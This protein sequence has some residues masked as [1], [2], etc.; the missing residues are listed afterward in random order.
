MFNL[1]LVTLVLCV[2]LGMKQADCVVYYV[3]SLRLNIK[4]GK[5]MS[6][7]DSPFSSSSVL[8]SLYI[9][10]I[11]VDMGAYACVT[12]TSYGPPPDYTSPPDYTCNRLIGGGG[13]GGGG[14]R[15]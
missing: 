7:D 10:H 13:G 2:S 15:P 1:I 5:Y 11:I 14:G 3:I 6:E 4:F 12:V 8:A 9:Y